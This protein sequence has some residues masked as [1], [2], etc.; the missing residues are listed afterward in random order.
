MK[1]VL[2]ASVPAALGSEEGSYAAT[3]ASSAGATRDARAAARRALRA[4]GVSA[5]GA[6][7]GVSFGSSNSC[8][9]C[10]MPW[11]GCGER[12]LVGGVERQDSIRISVREEEP[13]SRRGTNEA[14]GRSRATS[15]GGRARTRGFLRSLRLRRKGHVLDGRARLEHAQEARGEP[16]LVLRPRAGEDPAPASPRRERRRR[17]RRPGARV[18][19]GGGV[20]AGGGGVSSGGGGETPAPGGRGEVPQRC[21]RRLQRHREARLGLNEGA[22]RAPKPVRCCRT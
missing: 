11:F 12:G 21:R 19:P 10:A 17:S 14:A 8:T 1:S 22:E 16:G 7:G 18:R 2:Y 5:G 6:G 3:A 15:G 20:P 9:R 4:A 13:T